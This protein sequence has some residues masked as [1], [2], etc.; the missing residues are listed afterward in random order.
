LY[1]NCV[2]LFE[3]IFMYSNI[4]LLGIAERA[5]I[6]ADRPFVTA[7]WKAVTSKRIQFRLRSEYRNAHRK[8]L[9]A[10]NDPAAIPLPEELVPDTDA[11]T[12]ADDTGDAN[13]AN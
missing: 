9:A 6:M 7:I 4:D 8:L 13:P 1:D 3:L 5:A 12:G 10:G 11:D 2:A